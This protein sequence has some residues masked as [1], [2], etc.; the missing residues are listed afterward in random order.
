[1]EW[2]GVS[3]PYRC[4]LHVALFPTST[5]RQIGKFRSGHAKDFSE[6]PARHAALFWQS[7]LALELFDGFTCACALNSIDRPGCISQPRQ[8]LLNRTD[9]GFG[10]LGNLTWSSGT[11]TQHNPLQQCRCYKSRQR[12]PLIILIGQH[13]RTRHNPENS[14][15]GSGFITALRQLSLDGSH[16]TGVGDRRRGP[17]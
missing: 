7:S 10:F 3:M 17:L 4:Q 9:Q 6:K 13:C 14:I 16:S 15:N 5:G 12:Q 2:L 8:S 11:V 1:M